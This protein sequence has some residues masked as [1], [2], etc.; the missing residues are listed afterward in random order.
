LTAVVPLPAPATV[1]PSDEQTA[2]MVA[3]VKIEGEDQHRHK[4]SK[5]HKHKKEKKEKKER[6][7]KKRDREE[8]KGGKEGGGGG[9]DRKHGDKVIKPNLSSSSFLVFYFKRYWIS[10]SIWV[11]YGTVLHIHPP[12]PVFLTRILTI[13]QSKAPGTVLWKVVRIEKSLNGR[14]IAFFLSRPGF[15]QRSLGIQ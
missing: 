3:G 10:W 4:K 15:L 13:L 14:D 2:A 9:G 6:K 11:R 7:E 8:E 12:F 1:V 5:E